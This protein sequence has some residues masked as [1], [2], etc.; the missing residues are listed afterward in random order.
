MSDD[1]VMQAVSAIRAAARNGQTVELDI[2]V[3]RLIMLVAKAQ[4]RADAA[5]A[6]EEERKR[7]NRER[8]TLHRERNITS[9]SPSPPMINKS[10]TPLSPPPKISPAEPL[11][12]EF[13]QVYP[14][15]VGKGAARKAFRHAATRAENCRAIIDG[16]KR[17][18]ATKPDPQFTPHPT[19][20]L[21]ADRWLDEDGKVLSF[22]VGDGPKREF[23]EIKAEKEQSQ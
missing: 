12:D 11:F 9:P 22:R 10:S 7:A 18:A 5:D 14:R 23:R 1:E 17:F 6:R 21:N 20:W 16:A 4:A 15:K 19:S 13:W 3:D 2:A 8:V